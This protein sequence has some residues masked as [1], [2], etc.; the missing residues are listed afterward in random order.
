MR[1]R[2]WYKR[3]H[4]YFVLQLQCLLT[5]SQFRHRCAPVGF[6]TRWQC[7]ISKTA[8]AVSSTP[9]IVFYLERSIGEPVS[10]RWL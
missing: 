1:Y 3:K 5:S 10:P 2:R 6:L 7:I 8:S 9:S 4:R